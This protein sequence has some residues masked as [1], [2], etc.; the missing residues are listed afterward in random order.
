MKSRSISDIR[1][2]IA[3]LDPLEVTTLLLKLA[4]FS[5][6]NKELLSYLLFYTGLEDSFLKEVKAEIDLCFSDVNPRNAY[7]TK[8][9]IRKIIRLIKKY[10]QYASTKT[11]EI[12]IRLYFCQKFEEFRLH[13]LGDPPLNNIYDRERSKIEKLISTLHEDLQQDYLTELANLHR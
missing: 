7:L 3:H 13:R 5:T 8:K 6:A 9:T 10:A 1:K 12:E 4:K 2:E 11:L